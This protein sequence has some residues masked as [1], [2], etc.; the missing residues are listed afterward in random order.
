MAVTDAFSKSSR[1]HF[2]FFYHTK[3]CRYRES[4]IEKLEQYQIPLLSG[5]PENMSWFLQNQADFKIKHESFGWYRYER[6][7]KLTA[8]ESENC[9]LSPSLVQ[10][11]E[12][13]IAKMRQIFYHVLCESITSRIK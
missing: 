5:L 7:I 10:A 3:K 11:T 8:S 1:V 4:S 12:H 6:R 9:D 13:A 2:F